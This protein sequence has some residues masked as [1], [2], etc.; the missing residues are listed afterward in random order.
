MNVASS[1]LVAL[2]IFVIAGTASNAD[3]LAVNLA[4]EDQFQNRCD[5]AALRG[6]VV[7]LVYSG[8]HGAEAAVELGR[9]LHTHYH[10]SATDAE[11]A[12]RAKQP[13][14]GIAGWPTGVA[15]PNVHVIPVACVPEVPKMLRG[16]VR[17]Q[18]RKGSP[19]LPVWL[20]Y[21]DAMRKGFGIVPNEPNVLLLDTA[22]VARGVTV[23]QPDAAKYA[24]LL[25]SIDSLRASALPTLRTA[26]VPLPAV[27]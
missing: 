15:V 9:T 2:T 19:H 10:P 14:I 7:V 25:A 3:E 8:R 21:E 24:E 23:G 6:H 4:M 16:L 18:I 5:T 22:G 1:L 13:V 27:Q 11:P 12:E 20:D 26:A 17:S